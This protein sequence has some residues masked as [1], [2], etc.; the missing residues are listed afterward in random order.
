MF[1]VDMGPGCTER[2]VNFRLRRLMVM[3]DNRGPLPFGMYFL[4]FS[5]IERNAINPPLVSGRA[6]GYSA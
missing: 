5:A 2:E 3:S 6:V 1:L 4:E